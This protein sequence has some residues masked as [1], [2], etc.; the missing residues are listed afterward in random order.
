[1]RPEPSVLEVEEGGRTPAP[2][3]GTARD[4]RLASEKSTE[5]SLRWPVRW[6]PP[7][8]LP[9]FLITTAGSPV[10]A[11][12]PPNKKGDEGTRVEAGERAGEI[13][14]EAGEAGAGAADED[15]DEDADDGRAAAAGELL[16][17]VAARTSTAG[18]STVG[19][20]NTSGVLV[21]SSWLAGLALVGPAPA[22][23]A[24]REA[25]CPAD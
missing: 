18:V 6:V 23:T 1:M 9:G 22:A 3:L 17:A 14:K 8:P 20:A 10:A 7:A 13:A 11:G 24:G 21:L 19:T 15:A 16:S 2:A 4:S 12:A 5:F 25:S